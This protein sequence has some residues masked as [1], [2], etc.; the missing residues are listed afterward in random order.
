VP[1]KFAGRT[2]LVHDPTV[3][4]MR[5]TLDEMA[6][7]GRRTEARGA[8]GP[9]EVFLPRRGVS[10]IDAPGGPFEDSDADEACFAAIRDGLSGSS[11]VVHEL[12]SN[13]NDEGFGRAAAEAL[14]KLIT[15]H[16]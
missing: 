4:L 3:T 11:V 9:V 12:D 14:H 6:T 5:T 1:D 15:T 10:G 16:G 8:T 7:L 2:F 13:I